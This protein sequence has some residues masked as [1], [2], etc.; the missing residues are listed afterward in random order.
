[1][2]LETLG[3]D[4]G[5]F[6]EGV[7]G[8]FHAEIYLARLEKENKRRRKY[9]KSDQ[10]RDLPAK[11]YDVAELRRMAEGLEELRVVDP[12]EACRQALEIVRAVKHDGLQEVGPRS[13][14][15]ARIVL[16][17]IYRSRGI[18]STAAFF[19][20]DSLR[21]AG[22]TGSLK[23]RTLQGVMSLALD[24]GDREA[25]CAAVRQALTEYVRVG[26]WQGVGRASVSQGV[27]FGHY[28]LS[29]EAV[30]S[31]RQSL[32]LLP[33]EEWFG[34]FAAFEGLGL[35]QAYQQDPDAALGNV[36]EA[37][38]TLDRREIPR[39]YRA[40][41][42]WLRGEVLLLKDS[43]DKAEESFQAV[44]DI[45]ESEKV[46]E[47]EHALIS[48][49]LASVWQMSGEIE[50]IEELTTVLL[51]RVPRLSAR[52][53]L[54]AGSLAQLHGSVIRGELSAQVLA[55]TYREVLQEAKRAP[56][57]AGL[58]FNRSP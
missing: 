17:G 52:N 55:S 58:A 45:Y 56:L 29:A 51:G 14:C 42:L 22:R 16:G 25:A 18:W 19:L 12:D 11:A 33:N 24:Q 48:L 6:F 38:S 1:M 27:F 8:R 37:L 32:T 23:A 46:S 13:Q 10:Q 28:G 53:K 2:I 49:R 44:L 7:H 9:G 50:K 41:A 35:A 36:T 26:D 34:K 4:P 21:I 5:E 30:T 20:R 43:I 15:L 47:V 54:V 57:A 39:L 31:Y 3:V 40:G